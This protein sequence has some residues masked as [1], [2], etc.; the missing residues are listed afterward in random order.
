MNKQQQKGIDNGLEN[1][2]EKIKNET[3]DVLHNNQIITLRFIDR[4]N[5]GIKY[6]L[7]AFVIFPIHD[8]NS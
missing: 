2:Y 8:S 6:S 1:H 3:I 5:K 7:V 4:K